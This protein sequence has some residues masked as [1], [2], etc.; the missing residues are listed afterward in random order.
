[1][2]RQ[3]LKVQ[4]VYPRDWLCFAFS[5]LH[6]RFDQLT[7]IGLSQNDLLDDSN[8]TFMVSCLD[9]K[10]SQLAVSHFELRF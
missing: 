8:I 1:M 10:A 7:I 4:T 9:K 3:A 2:K 5:C 6:A